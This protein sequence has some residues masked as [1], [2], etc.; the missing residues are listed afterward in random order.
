MAGSSEAHDGCLPGP[1]ASWAFFV[2][3][4]IQTGARR[5]KYRMSKIRPSSVMARQFN[6]RPLC[7]T[8][9]PI[10]K[11]IP[12]VSGCDNMLCN[13]SMDYNWVSVAL[14]VARGTIQ[15]MSVGIHFQ[16]MIEQSISADFLR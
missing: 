9:R 13:I 8:G 10:S 3:C 11:R 5:V 12:R 15:D 2:N 7:I 1:C 6:R 14:E 4:D 16:E